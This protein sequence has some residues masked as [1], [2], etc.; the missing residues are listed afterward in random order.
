MCVLCGLPGRLQRAPFTWAVSGALWSCA[1][2]SSP[3]GAGAGCTNQKA[4]RELAE[5]AYVLQFCS[6][7]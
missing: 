4:G 3:P 1:V 6:S 2:G 7:Q 5:G